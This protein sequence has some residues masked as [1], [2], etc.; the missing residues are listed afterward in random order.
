[1]FSQIYEQKV[2]KG[3]AEHDINPYPDSTESD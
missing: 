3:E 2:S 1:M